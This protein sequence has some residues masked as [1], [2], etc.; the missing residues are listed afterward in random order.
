M[1]RTRTI[2][3]TLYLLS[4]IR[5]YRSRKPVTVRRRIP[6]PMLCFVVQGTGVLT[7]N[8]SVHS[9]GPLQLF[10]LP[11]GTFVEAAAKSGSL[12]YYLIV[13]DARTAIKR[14][15]HWQL[16]GSSELPPLLSRGHVPIGDGKQ[17]HRRIEELY[18]S[19]TLRSGT[20]PADP[21]RQ[22]QSLIDFIIRD[23]AAKQEASRAD[24]AGIDRC[25]AYMRHY[26]HEKITRNTLADIAKLTPNAFC[27]SFKRKTGL[28]PTD[29]LNRI[30]IDHAKLL[31]SPGS[32]VKDVAS[33]VGYSSEYYFS[34]IFKE[35]V[36]LPPTLFIKRE[37]LKVAIASRWGLQDNLS[38]MGQEAVSAVD[39]YKYPGAGEAEHGLR[40]LAQL[41][42]LR[43]A[44]PDLIIGDYAHL[45]YYDEFK[46]IAPTVILEHNLDWRATHLKIAELVG[47]EREAI[48][49]FHQ[50]DESIDEARNRLNRANGTKTVTIMQVI[51]GL[52]RIQG[53][54]HHPL[55]ELIYKE[56]G[57]LPGR[58]VPRNKMR[59]E[60][61]P[62]EL[63]AV[64]TDQLFTITFGNRNEAEALVS[65][66]Q[67]IPETPL[68][69]ASRQPEPLFVPN[70]LIMS[71][72]PGGRRRIIEQVVEALAAPQPA[73][74]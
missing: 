15:G 41:E 48:Q 3:H 36:G 5:K 39:C 11:P 40:I 43:L 28:S 1:N 34:R 26:F 59:D 70:W 23:L 72:T 69:P 30:R 50:L 47:R 37:R 57:L 58:S 10:Y 24:D 16:A 8:E 52:L 21:D 18:D 66:L 2:P 74:N 68:S 14:K 62:E 73:R 64:E 6:V 27:R 42:Q 4:S 13:I 9:I 22:L 46:Q 17:A 29:F 67:L 56:L 31:L 51:P 45:A 60:W 71:W 35:F 44:A 49:T 54:I 32:T 7:L 20:W 61:Q 63:T 19:L 25:I 38:S 53:T 33:A 12:E 55:N 65:K